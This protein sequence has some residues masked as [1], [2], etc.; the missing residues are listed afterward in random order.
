M[1]SDS[2]YG[3]MMERLRIH[4]ERLLSGH[5]YR[6]ALPQPPILQ[7]IPPLNRQNPTSTHTPSPTNTPTSTSSYTATYT[8][9]P[10]FTTTFTPTNTPTL[11]YTSTPTQ[12]Y[13]STPSP[14]ELDTPTP[15]GT[16]IPGDIN[17]DG[18]INT[19]DLFLFSN[20]WHKKS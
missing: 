2:L 15:T 1:K 20:G 18:D 19:I 5:L 8:S 11:T 4:R 17:G 10:T 9:S 7:H 12:T 3:M 13:T 6:Q 14:T 16:P